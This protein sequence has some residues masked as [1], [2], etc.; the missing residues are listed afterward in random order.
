MRSPLACW[1]ASAALAAFALWALAPVDAAA[2]EIPRLGPELASRLQSNLPAEGL[3]VVVKLREAGLPDVSEASRASAV[4]ARQERALEGVPEGTFSDLRG[5]SLLAGLAL[6]ADRAAIEALVAHPEVERVYLDGTVRA[7]LAQG[8]E[9]IGAD[10]AAGVGIQGAGVAVAVLDTGVDTDHPD[11]ASNLLAEACF[12]DDAPGP[13]GCCGGGGQVESGPGSAE[14]DDGHGTSVAGIVA[15]PGG[16]APEVDL[17]AIRVLGSAGSGRFSDVDAALDWLLA[18]GPALGV[19][20]VNLSFGDGGEFGSASQFPCSGSV[21]ADAMAQLHGAG[22]S[23]FASSGNEAHTAGVSFPACVAEALAVGGVYDAALGNVSWCANATC[24]EILCRDLDTSADDFVCHTNRGETLALLAPNWRTRTSAL[25][26]GAANFGGTSASSPYA[27]GQ[28]ALLYGADP[29][30]SPD[31]VEYLL[32][33]HGPLVADAGSGLSFRR[34]DVAAALTTHLGGED[35]DGD[36]IPDDGDLS[37]T[38]GDAPCTG[39]QSALCDD[40]CPSAANPTQADADADGVGDACDLPCDNG[41]D[42]DGDGAID[43]P[44]DE[45]CASTNSPT[46]SPAC[47]DG[48]DNDG[49]GGIDFDGD[50]PDPQCGKPSQTWEERQGCGLGV[51]LG[52]LAPLLGHLARRRRRRRQRG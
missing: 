23:I 43:Y 19:R 22:V 37:G 36:G 27:A 21:T 31:G 16:V 38:V 11:L 48:I 26:G 12:C 9:L 41:L 28:A 44:D 8:T 51:E 13:N 40:N 7:T 24:S 25:G 29:G 47:S 33:V 5:H 10:L 52:L 45:G 4:W 3:P 50:P 46:E 39:G 18:N 34:S 30:L 15:S 14:D 49:D 17:V 2:E 35:S 42:D 20:V 32:R 6:R 1:I